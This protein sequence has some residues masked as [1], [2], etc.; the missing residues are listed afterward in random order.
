MGFTFIREYLILK[1]SYTYFLTDT[2][3]SCEGFTYNITRHGGS[4]DSEQIK[5]ASASQWSVLSRHLVEDL[6]DRKKHEVSPNLKTWKKYNFFLVRLLQ[7]QSLDIF[8]P[9]LWLRCQELHIKSQNELLIQIS[10]NL[11][12]LLTYVLIV[13]LH[14]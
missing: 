2:Y 5:M 7:F 9:Q 3:Y 10:K 8:A 13:G 1:N 14:C 4:P 11:L 12:V 6:L